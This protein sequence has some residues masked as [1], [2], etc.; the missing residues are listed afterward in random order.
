MTNRLSKYLML[1]LIV[2]F[3]INSAG[4]A[5]FLQPT[6]SLDH[7]VYSPEGALSRGGEYV[8]GVRDDLEIAVWRCPELSVKVSVRPADGKITMPLIGELKAA[9]LTARELAMAISKKMAYY[10]KEPRIAVAVLKIGE[11]K[12]FL[13]G[14][15]R[16]Q[17]NYELKRGDRIIDIIARA[18]G[19]TENAVPS[20]AHIV[21]GGYEDSEII[22]VSLT[23]L[24]KNGD[25]SQNVF[26][27]EG[28][29]V[30][31]PENEIEQVNYVIRQIFPSMFFT[32]KLADIQQDFV[33]GNLDIKAVMNKIR[34]DYP[35]SRAGN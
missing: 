20:A 32:E 3:S 12:V 29:I 22:R 24:I 1:F 23:R 9:E 11:K 31:I 30:F 4:C 8:I 27:K 35:S 21:R 34:G 19:F 2:I 17:G 28:D 13:L 25:I 16:R 6:Q 26:L 14:E 33:Q 18:G 10:V 15:V 7:S 5:R